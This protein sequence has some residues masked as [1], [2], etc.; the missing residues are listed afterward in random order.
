MSSLTE[1]ERRGLEDVFL[2]IS[3]TGNLL[4]RCAA[5]GRNLSMLDTLK[6][7]RI[8]IS[9]RS[10]PIKWLKSGLKKHKLRKVLYKTEKR[11]KI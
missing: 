11:R 10:K 7:I 8:P 5:W 4:Q 3:S 2:S 1:Q 9:F 6:Q